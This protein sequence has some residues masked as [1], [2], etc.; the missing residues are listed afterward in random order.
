MK[1]KPKIKVTRG[2]RHYEGVDIANLP[3]GTD[4]DIADMLTISKI[5]ITTMIDTDIL[6]ELKVRAAKNGSGRY[7]TYLNQ[8]LRD[9]LFGKRAIDENRVKEIVRNL[10]KQSSLKRKSQ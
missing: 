5:R 3:E 1:S 10:V 2:I 6:Q 4:E 9:V 7:Q 8:L